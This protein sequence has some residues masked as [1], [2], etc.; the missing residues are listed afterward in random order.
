MPAS[1]AEMTGV[2]ADSDAGLNTDPRRWLGPARPGVWIPVR[3]LKVSGPRCRSG[4]VTEMTAMPVSGLAVKLPSVGLMA[5]I[6]AEQC[7]VT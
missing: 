3:N 4:S 1:E 2:N 5:Q 6:L 7:T